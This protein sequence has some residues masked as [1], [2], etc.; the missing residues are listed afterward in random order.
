LPGFLLILFRAVRGRTAR[1]LGAA[2]AG[3]VVG[4]A[5]MLVMLVA[6]P[7]F[8]G[9]LVEHLAYLARAVGWNGT[10][11]L[12]K[13]VQWPWLV[14]A[15]DLPVLERWHL[16]CL[17]AL[18]I[19]VPALYLLAAA[20]VVRAQDDT[21]GRRLVLAAGFI[22]VMYANYTFARPDLEHLA[23]NIH[24]LVILVTGSVAALGSRWRTRAIAPGLPLVLAISG[25]TVSVKNPAY[26]WAAAHRN[27]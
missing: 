9:G 20:N 22:G 6:V 3:V 27:P 10:P 25:L 4:Y 19:A 7:G 16:R 14:G 26:F 24:L 17:G 11:N 12:A 8:F 23:Q 2:A 5:P 21:P 15:D 1:G 18:F 13:P